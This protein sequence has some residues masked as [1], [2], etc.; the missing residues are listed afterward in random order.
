MPAV[1]LQNGLTDADTLAKMKKTLSWLLANLDHWNVKRLYT[2][3]CQ[4][5]SENG[6]TQILGPLLIMKDQAGTTRLVM[7]YDK[8]NDKFVFNMYDA[9]GNLTIT[10]NDSGEAIF[11]GNIQTL[12]DA[13]IGD[14][15]Y[16]GDMESGQKAILLFNSLLGACGIILNELNNMYIDN[17]AGSV[18]IGT[19][20]PTSNVNIG[21]NAVDITSDSVSVTTTSGGLIWIKTASGGITINVSG[22]SEDLN[23]INSGNGVMKIESRGNM[24]IEST[25]G[26]TY[27]DG[28]WKISSPHKG[29]F[30]YAHEIL[31]RSEI[32][33]IMPSI[34]GGDSGSFT[35][36]DGKTVTVS[37][38]RITS[39][40]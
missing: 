18:N 16:V 26:N 7:G 25:H 38:G 40:V 30:D 2:E 10:E 5:S 33:S 24:S 36:A 34:P 21:G 28:T 3:Y 14:N 8:E 13:Y 11:S 20:S 6:E 9:S 15:L 17:T 1:E 27:A 32:E 39:I 37:D 4:V 35:T 23:I 31:N 12:K 19:Q 22:G 29:G